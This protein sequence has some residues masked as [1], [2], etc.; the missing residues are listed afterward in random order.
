MTK[1]IQ[2]KP[3]EDAPI[4]NSAQEHA[5]EASADGKPEEQDMT[6]KLEAA[7]KEA[8]E[9]KDRYLRTLAD[10][11]NLRKRH[12]REK[13]EL[14]QFATTR[15]LE[16]L[17]PVLDNLGFAISGAENSHSSSVQ[18]IIEGVNMITE[19]IK[20]TLASHGLSEVNPLNQ[21]F[22]PNLHEAVSHIPDAKIPA[23]HVISV[24][25]VGYT[26]NG[27][28]LR[29]ASVVVSSGPQQG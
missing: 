9:N 6:S 22:D 5:P 27:R 29:P 12:L 8:S 24:T 4:Q 28:L 26:L 3:Q 7:Q 15:I 18:S 10:M 2:N 20:K 19:Q 23:D 11:E 16:D 13:D 17:L 14:R 21:A 1:D 25:R